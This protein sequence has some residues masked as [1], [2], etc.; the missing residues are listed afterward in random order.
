MIRE[1]LTQGHSEAEVERICSGN[2]LRVWSR[3]E[4]VAA[5]L[6]STSQAAD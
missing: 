6:Q 2:V 5:E 4:Q 1:L 3:V